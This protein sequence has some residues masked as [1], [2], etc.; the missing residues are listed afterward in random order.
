[1]LIS[2]AFFIKIQIGWIYFKQEINDGKQNLFSSHEC[3]TQRQQQEVHSGVENK[4]C[5]NL[6]TYPILLKTCNHI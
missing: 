1:M 2:G 5:F 4:E 3:G 6:G